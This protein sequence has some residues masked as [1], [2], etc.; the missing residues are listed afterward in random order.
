MWPASALN[1]ALLT[2]ITS[3]KL[4]AKAGPL[5]GQNCILYYTRVRATL[6][7]EEVLNYVVGRNRLSVSLDDQPNIEEQ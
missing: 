3:Q 1:K 2:W 6:S 5:L 7:R 4:R